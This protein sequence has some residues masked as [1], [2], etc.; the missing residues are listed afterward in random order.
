MLFKIEP[1]SLDRCRSTQLSTPEMSCCR[2]LIT[3]ASSIRSS[4]R[5]CSWHAFKKFHFQV[6][7]PSSWSPSWTAGALGPW[8][9]VARCCSPV[10]YGANPVPSTSFNLSLIYSASWNASNG[11]IHAVNPTLETILNTKVVVVSVHMYVFL[12]MWDKGEIRLPRQGKSR[13]DGAVESFR[14]LHHEQHHR[15]SQDITQSLWNSNS[16]YLKLLQPQ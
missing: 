5:G 7:L 2:I 3:I 16:K 11:Y 12:P 6:H 15:K 1:A 10:R 9:K 14:S 13:S 4:K 8:P